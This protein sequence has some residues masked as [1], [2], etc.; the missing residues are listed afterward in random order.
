[1]CRSTCFGRLHAHHQELITGLTA[2][3]FT[4]ERGGSSVV[5]RG[6]WLVNLF[7]LYDDARICQ[8]QKPELLCTTSYIYLL[9]VK[10][11]IVST[12]KHAA[13]KVL[14]NKKT[15]IQH[16]L[17]YLC[18]CLQVIMNKNKDD[19]NKRKWKIRTYWV[20]AKH[21]YSLVESTCIKNSFR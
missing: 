9:E 16:L 7:E 17:F 12:S 4:L 3:G 5:G 14:H 20:A 8:R 6:I 10:N 11:V 1:M 13:N 2:S 18:K 19:C 15:D 21:K